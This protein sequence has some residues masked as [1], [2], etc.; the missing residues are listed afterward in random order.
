[1]IYAILPRGNNYGWGLC[2]KYIVKELSE[3]SDVK[4]ITE[5][6]TV[7]DIGDEVEYHFLRNKLINGNEVAGISS[8]AIRNV[9][10]PILQAIVD[11]SLEP[12]LVNLQGTYKLGYTFFEM[13][14]L[15]E[16]YIQNGRKHYDMI[17][18]GSRWCEDVLKGHGL[19]HVTTVIQGI[20]TQ[21]FNPSHSEKEFF[22][23]HFVV[24]SGGKFEFRKAQDI[25]IRA[26]KVLQDRHPDVLLVN[27]WY[28]AWPNS[29][30]S[31]ALSPHISV[32]IDSSDYLTLVNRI[33]HDNGIDLNRVITLSP[34]PN[35]QLARIYKNTD[36][37]L[38]PNRCEGGTNLVLMEYMACGKP[39]IASYSS[40]HKDI[41]KEGNSIMITQM[42]P[43]TIPL[44]EL[45]HAVWD[46][47]DLD[48]TI[49][50][51]EWAYQ[52][53][54]RLH[55]IGR[56]GGADLSQITWKKTGQNFYR[57]LTQA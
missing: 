50:H 34:K 10:A 37:G 39:V 33:L 42:K 45:S 4:Y 32:T 30:K 24:F 2:G 31:M 22:K 7:N 54:E 55:P 14:V 6:F 52:N 13:N 21:L 8:G 28:N 53:R 43:V 9:D 19:N 25:V 5:E 11:H 23:D 41:L 12:W 48:E 46:D 57:L 15:H 29:I 16:Q 40:G 17:V 27:A 56:Q 35:A 1:M 36:I 20:D 47:P 18:T 38:F 44:N 26:Y 51:L 3:L 49:D